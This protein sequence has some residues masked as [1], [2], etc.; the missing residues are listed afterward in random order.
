LIGKQHHNVL[1]TGHAELVSA[2]MNVSGRMVAQTLKQVQGGAG[3]W[4]KKMCH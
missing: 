4:R 1:Q 3:K 2:S